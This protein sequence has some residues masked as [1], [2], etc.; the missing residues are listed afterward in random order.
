MSL[1]TLSPQMLSAIAGQREK[2]IVIQVQAD[3]APQ[4]EWITP[5]ARSVPGKPP[6]RCPYTGLSRSTLLD[7]IVE[8][9]GTEHEVVIKHRR[10]AGADK[11]VILIHYPSLNAYLHSLPAWKEAKVLETTEQD[12]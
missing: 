10:K 11:G 1:A 5:P 8:S 7:L 4:P 12:N 3:H 9:I 2:L 6:V